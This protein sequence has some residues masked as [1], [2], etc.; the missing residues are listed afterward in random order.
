MFII[1]SES[2]VNPG[3]WSG[4]SSNDHGV[5]QESMLLIQGGKIHVLLVAALDTIALTQGVSKQGPEVSFCTTIGRSNQMTVR[6][7]YT[8]NVRFLH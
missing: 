1:V 5:C 6:C 3:R 7:S 4:K 8:E 2:L